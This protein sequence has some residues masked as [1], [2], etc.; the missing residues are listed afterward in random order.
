V[1]GGGHGFGGAK[2]SREELIEKSLRFFDSKLKPE[3]P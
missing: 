3:S 2:D 1:V